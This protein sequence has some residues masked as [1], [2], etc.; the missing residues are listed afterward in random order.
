MSFFF[1]GHDPPSQAIDKTHGFG[2]FTQ[3]LI[4]GGFKIAQKF[5]PLNWQ[6]TFLERFYPQKET[7]FLGFDKTFL[8]PREVCGIMRAFNAGNKDSE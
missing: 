1:Y 3:W 8:G 4:H 2:P 5:L 7:T 6:T